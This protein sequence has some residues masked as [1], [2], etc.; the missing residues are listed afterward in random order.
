MISVLIPV[1][2]TNV[3]A[4]VN[5]VQHLLEASVQDYQIIVIDDGSDDPISKAENHQLH[6][7]INVSYIE[8]SENVGRSRI[9]NKLMKLARYENLIFLDCDVR[10]DNEDFISN[11]LKHFDKPVVCGGIDYDQKSPEAGHLLHWK[12][13]RQKEALSAKKRNKTFPP[14]L[15]TANFMVK[16]DV[17]NSS[18][19]DENIE[20]YGYEDVAWAYDLFRKQI[21]IF[22]IDNPVVH[23][24]LSDNAS[25]LTKTKQ[26]LQNLT[27]LSD[28]GKI[29]KTPLIKY[30]TLV[31]KLPLF[32]RLFIASEKQME[33]KLLNAKGGSILFDLWK[34]AHL[35]QIQSV[36]EDQ[37]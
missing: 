8:S 19:F 32:R 20:G 17:L 4:L 35:L 7:L 28:Q 3:R 13:G 22:H 31:D 30:V 12:I 21:K 33:N 10:I 6:E 1:Y 14:I 11:Y 27:M 5:R 37:H 23:T 2:N 36:K 26:A 24:G 18:Y 16:A 29:G 9:R 34:I 25:F 15:F